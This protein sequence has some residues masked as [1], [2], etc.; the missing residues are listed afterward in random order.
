MS[1]VA[2][3]IVA[4]GGGGFSTET[5]ATLLDDFVLSLGSRTPARICFLPTASGD[6]APYIV[7]FYRAFSRRA[8]ATDVTIFD[9]S[10]LRRHPAKSSE[11][12]DVIAEQ[13]IVYVGG[14]NTAHLLST[15]RMHGVD[16]A[17][18]AAWSR[19]AILCG[20]SAGMIC[21]FR[22]GITDSFGALRAVGG[23]LGLIDASACPHYDSQEARRHAVHEAIARGSPAGYAAD[24][25]VAL[26]FRGTQLA[27]AV[28]AR[29]EAF[30]YRVALVDGRV[31]ET[32]IV[33]RYL[34]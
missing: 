29:R 27:E 22:D 25:G 4:L 20:V 28:S 1:G 12:A 21:W 33:P 9:P 11:I 26:H 30:A 19:G 14:G 2:G 5:G 6:S 17:L 15:W 13:D 16:T 24:E 10:L 3:Q 7:N 18:R 32:R 34:G 8:L 23:G 31:E